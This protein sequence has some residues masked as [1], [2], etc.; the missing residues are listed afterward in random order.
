MGACNM[1]QDRDVL[2]DFRVV[3]FADAELC[4]LQICVVLHN[5]HV[6]ACPFRE[7]ITKNTKCG[8]SHPVLEPSNTKDKTV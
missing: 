6:F 3:D 4:T 5:I 8:V 7:Y 2:I 1:K